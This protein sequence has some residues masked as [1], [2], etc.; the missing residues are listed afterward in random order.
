MHID[1]FT[2]PKFRLAAS[3]AIALAAALA[4][5]AQAGVASSVSL[6]LSAP[7]GVVGDVTPVLEHATLDTSLGLHAGDAGNQIS[8]FWMLPTES[9]TFSGNSILLHLLAGAQDPANSSFVTGYLAD[10]GNPAAY[11]FQGLP[12]VGFAITGVSAVNLG[13]VFGSGVSTQLVN[14]TEV[15]F[16][17]DTLVFD[18]AQN[19]RDSNGYYYADIRL[20]LTMQPVP[21]PAVWAL[22][23]V[24]LCTLRL[25]RRRAA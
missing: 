23:L 7:G 5:P 17:L 1:L 6:T 11:V 3:A 13:G 4:G 16:R 9:I 22:A 21:E 15:D 18:T 2:S 19:L 25:A 20:D 12:L 14:G 24:G 8:A 10:G